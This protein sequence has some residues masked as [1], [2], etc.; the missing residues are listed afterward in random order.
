MTMANL[1]QQSL[2]PLL[3][4]SLLT[5]AT[6]ASLCVVFG[7]G[8]TEALW[9]AYLFAMLATWPVVMGAV[10]LLALGNL[11]GGRWAAAARPFY[12]AAARTLPFVAVLLVPLAFA[13]GH[14]YPWAQS[15]AESPHVF[16]PAKSAYLSPPFF[17]ARS[18]AYIAVWLVVSWWLGSVSQYTRPPAS[19][20]AMRRAGAL[21]LVL[22]V[23]TTTFAAF[24]WGMSLEPHWYSSIYGAILTG[25]GVVAAHALAIVGLACVS[26]STRI[27]LV[28]S[29]GT[30][31]HGEHEL[32]DVYNDMG[33]LLLAFIMLWTYFSFSQFFIIW[34]GNLPG[35]AAWYERRLSGG[36]QML[37]LALVLSC[38]ALPFLMLLSRNFKRNIRQ[39][40]I[41]AAVVLAGYSL[42][43][44]WMFV[45]ALAPASFV[46][47][48]ANAGAL[49]AV[50]GVWLA[51]YWW[52]IGR[53]RVVGDL[54]DLQ[55][56][57][58]P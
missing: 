3:T 48:M 33:N 51:L 54:G 17:L 34:S 35:E 2:R 12:L 32:A 20:P 4:M 27:S 37:A 9:R 16:S 56:S 30:G 25:G 43:M 47:S 41:V 5:A 36:W 29:A 28:S 18:A 11:T 21:S 44:Y 15:G 10:G 31:G 49:M 57:A 7:R 53:L 45:P 8:E 42:N 19:T 52:Q 24:D 22:L 55:A 14:I 50:G 1:L 46:H 6:G 40:A 58:E 23:P 26:L 13:L 38:F 39:L